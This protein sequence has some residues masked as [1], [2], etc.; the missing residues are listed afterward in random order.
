[1]LKVTQTI[2]F[3]NPFLSLQAYNLEPGHEYEFRVR[4]KNAAGFS[5]YSGSSQLF[6][7]RGRAGPP[8]P[9]RDPRAARVGKN[10]VDLSWDPP[11]S[12]GGMF[13]IKF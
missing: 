10:Y 9:P 8:L 2:Y 4:A 7:P 11:A 12:D 5:K 6:K 13:R 3:L 1:M